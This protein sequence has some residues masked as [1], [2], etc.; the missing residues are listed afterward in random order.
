MS[1]PTIRQCFNRQQDSALAKRCPSKEQGLSG[2]VWAG[3][4][5]SVLVCLDLGGVGLVW[6][7]LVWAGLGWSGLVWAGL[8]WS[9]VVWFGLS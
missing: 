7:G 5:W 8:G 4:G 9:G 2:F 3:L 1:Q 6:A